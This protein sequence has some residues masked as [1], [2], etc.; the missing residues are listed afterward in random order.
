MKGKLKSLLE[1]R[2]IAAIPL[3]DIKIKIPAKKKIE[4][5]KGKMVERNGCPVFGR[6]VENNKLPKIPIKYNKTINITKSNSIS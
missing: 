4:T 2:F 5:I 1:R 3:N 6:K